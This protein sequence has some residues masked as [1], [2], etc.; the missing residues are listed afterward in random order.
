MTALGEGTAPQNAA[1]DTATNEKLPG[2]HPEV[3]GSF[4]QDQDG[5]RESMSSDTR[6]QKGEYDDAAEGMD[7]DAT[8]ENG[9]GNPLDRV[10]SQAQRLGK[11]KIAVVMGALCLVLFLAALD[12]VPSPAPDDVSY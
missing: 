3:E 10:P 7:T 2:P 1:V 12:M 4:A 8:G 6:A 5:V 9:N 11:K